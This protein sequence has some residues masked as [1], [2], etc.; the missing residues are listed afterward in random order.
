[1]VELF[2]KD[3]DFMI[4]WKNGILHTLKNE[5]EVHY[6][7][8][9]DQG[10]IIGFDDEIDHLNFDQVIDLKG[11]HLYPGFVDAHLHI[12]GYG[13]KLSKKDLTLIR[14]KQE[15]IDY[16][17]TYVSQ[18]FTFYEGYFDI[19]ITKQD[20]DMIAYDK[21]IILKHNDYHSLTVNSYVLEQVNLLSETGFLTEEDAQKVNKTY[22]VY[23]HETIKAMIKHSIDSL[24]SFGVTGGHS[25]D[26][27]YFNGY[28]DTLSAYHEVLA[29][30]PFRAHLLMHHQI[31]DDYMK[32]NHP[33]LDQ[34]KYL[35]LGAVKIFYDGTFS[36]KTA[37][38]HHPY[39][40][41]SHQGLRI[42]KQDELITL[43]KKVRKNKLP[44]AIHVIGDLGLRE[45]VETLKAYPPHQG[46]HDR[47]IHA[48]LADHKTIK[49]ME[50][51]PI[52]LDIQPQFISSDLPS[53][54]NLFSKE[55][56]YIYPFK[57]YMNHN[58]VQCG[59][60]D[61]PV[62]IPNPLLGMYQLI[63]RKKDGIVYQKEECI[64]RFDAL[65]LYTTYANVPT[66]KTNRGLLRKG[67]IADFT[68]LKKDILSM[69]EQSFFEDLVEMTVIDEQI[70]H[71]A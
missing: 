42:F 51:M 15:I 56:E 57:T 33:F 67:F 9:T 4:L 49:M 50:G 32:S 70:V 54:L 7:M 45:V 3:V 37:L 34:N 65:K 66:Y 41:L 16:I 71:H 18:G 58:L 59:S 63:Y 35:Q 46:L 17:K 1:M 53:I 21:P 29:E 6:Q 13:Q 5:H 43:V 48:S 62:E 38:L 10:H 25:D 61:A 8:A 47:I 11:H 55:P 31:L 24:Q 14:N 22:E 26:L 19:G 27:Y 28:H 12:V 40:G 52:I 23:D 68:V 60:S 39:Q 2:F 30:K 64:S 20:L 44:L 36:S 69:D